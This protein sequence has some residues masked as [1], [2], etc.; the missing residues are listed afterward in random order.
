MIDSIP[1]LW[2]NSRVRQRQGKVI[3]TGKELIQMKTVKNFVIFAVVVFCAWAALSFVEVSVKNREVCPDYSSANF[4]LL[5]EDV[6][7]AD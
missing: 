5:M 3:K 6:L 4:F 2:Y 7:R 1:D